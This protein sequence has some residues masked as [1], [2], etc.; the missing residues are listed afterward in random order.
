MTSFKSQ[1]LQNDPANDTSRRWRPNVSQST[2]AT[3]IHFAP[4][5]FEEQTTYRKWRRA[6]LIFYGVFTLVTAAITIAIGPADPSTAARDSGAH[7]TLASVGQ[8]HPH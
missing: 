8:R 7:S 6:M 5:T 4:L 1:T 3:R 2:S